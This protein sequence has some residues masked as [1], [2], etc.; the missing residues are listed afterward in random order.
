MN[1]DGFLSAEV[2]DKMAREL[3]AKERTS[4]ADEPFAKADALE[5]KKTAAFNA[6]RKAITKGTTRRNL[7]LLANE[8]MIAE[9]AWLIAV[10]EVIGGQGA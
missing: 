1:T 5:E 9:K 7:D 6:V 4:S 10:C 8:F 2:I 3:A